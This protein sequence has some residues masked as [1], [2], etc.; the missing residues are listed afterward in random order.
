MSIHDKVPGHDHFVT[1]PFS[2]NVDGIG[3]VVLG[4]MKPTPTF[5]SIDSVFKVL[6]YYRLSI[7][8]NVN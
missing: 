7:I 8:Q 1:D 2:V 4:D 6:N 3:T 5:S